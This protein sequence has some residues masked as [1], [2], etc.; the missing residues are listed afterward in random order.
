MI[1]F[2]AGPKRPNEKQYVCVKYYDVKG[3]ET[4]REFMSPKFHLSIDNGHMM[5]VEEYVPTNKDEK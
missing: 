1:E 2:E 5:I 4:D 3:N